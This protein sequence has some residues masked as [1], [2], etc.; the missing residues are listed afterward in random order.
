MNKFTTVDM[1]K[2]PQ[3]MEPHEIG[4]ALYDIVHDWNH[5]ASPDG[6]LGWVTRK[7]MQILKLACDHLIA[8][9]VNQ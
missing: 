9:G 3:D 2:D 1:T 7:E 8:L 5:G 4:L 6:A